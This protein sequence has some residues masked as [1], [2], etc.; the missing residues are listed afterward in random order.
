MKRKQVQTDTLNDKRKI[1]S[2]NPTAKLELEP[3]E[4]TNPKYSSLAP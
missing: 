1:R 2:S 3:T 4:E